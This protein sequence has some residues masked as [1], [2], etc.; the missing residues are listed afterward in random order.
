MPFGS[1]TFWLCNAIWVDYVVS[2]HVPFIIVILL[3][4]TCLACNRPRN[5]D[6]LFPLS[7]PCFNEKFRSTDFSGFYSSNRQAS[8]ISKSF[9]CLAV[10]KIC[11]EPLLLGEGCRRRVQVHLSLAFKSWDTVFACLEISVPGTQKIAAA[12]KS[13]LVLD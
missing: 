10:E 5:N 4:G 3:P 11:N 13:L 2:I 6:S 7:S 12:M 1:I 8:A 9:Q